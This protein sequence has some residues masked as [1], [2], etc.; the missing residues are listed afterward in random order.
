MIIEKFKSV[1]FSL[2]ELFS[3][4]SFIGLCYCLFYKYHFY[5]TLGIPWFITNLSPQ[6]IFF[7]SLK[8]I[9][10]ASIYLILGS[11]VGYWFS[12]FAHKRIRAGSSPLILV[13]VFAYFIIFLFFQHRLPEYVLYLKIS[14][15]LFS[16]LCVNFGVYLGAFYHQLTLKND[17]I[18]DDILIY[19]RTIQGIFIKYKKETIY[20]SSLFLLILFIMQPMYF[21]KSEALKI[22]S[23]KEIYL[24][25]ALLKDSIKDWYLIESMGD[26]VLLIDK[27]NN[28]KIVE[29]KELDFIQTN[30]KS[31]N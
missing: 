4:F 5:N 13:S 19:K 2:L 7:A 29:Y 26:K 28:I 8:L 3:L 16:Y 15:F 24:S 21:G 27:K 11:L 14:D 17:V 12:I 23:Y 6:F 25:K 22:I 31:N 18:N 1:Q 9:I 10:F 30:K 20:I